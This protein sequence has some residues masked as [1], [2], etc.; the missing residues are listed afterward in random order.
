MF[1]LD[2]CNIVNLLIFQYMY[3]L[4]TIWIKSVIKI[5]SARLKI[6]Y[7]INAILINE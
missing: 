1:Q 4:N 2:L 6:V 3:L 7:S 5:V